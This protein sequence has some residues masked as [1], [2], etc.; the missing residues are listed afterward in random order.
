MRAHRRCHWVIE[1]GGKLLEAKHGVKP[2]D[3]AKNACVSSRS[4]SLLGFRA[5]LLM[6]VLATPSSLEFIKSLVTAKK[7]E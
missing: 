7:D 1:K 3:D 4:S 6:D 5:H 2:A